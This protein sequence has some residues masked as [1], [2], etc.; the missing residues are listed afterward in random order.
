VLVLHDMRRGLLAVCPPP[1]SP[2]ESH[3][4]F[5][6][7]PPFMHL[8]AEPPTDPVHVNLIACYLSYSLATLSSALF[9]P[10][11]LASLPIDGN[12]D[13]EGASRDAALASQL[14]ELLLAEG[15]LEWSPHMTDKLP[16]PQLNALLKRAYTSLIQSSSEYSQ[17]Y[18]NTVFF[19][20]CYGLLCLIETRGGTIK[21]D[22][23]WD[24][25]T[26]FCVSL[27]QRTKSSGG[28]VLGHSL[29]L[30]SKIMDR[31][32]LRGDA[33]DFKASKGFVT[34][35]ELWLDLARNVR[36]RPLR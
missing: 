9:S 5:G 23:L 19:L 33:G 12:S 4:A 24:Q 17:T 25:A 3:E 35:C 34:F 22:T 15:I 36:P 10:R 11:H 18:P 31:V 20:R 29:A 27:I 2:Q 8:P 16:V 32:E 7:C 30:M 28:K 13:K 6:P 14:Q 26:R 1:P 21:P